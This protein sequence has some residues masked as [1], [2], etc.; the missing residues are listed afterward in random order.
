MDVKHP[1]PL[2]YLPFQ[3]IMCPARVP[4]A[5]NEAQMG[6]LY[7]LLNDCCSYRIGDRKLTVYSL[8]NRRVISAMSTGTLID[9]SMVN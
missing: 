9:E 1:S 7:L 2:D 3:P 5:R 8:T 4:W 6:E